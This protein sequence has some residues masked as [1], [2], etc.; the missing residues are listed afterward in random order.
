MSAVVMAGGRILG[1]G[2]RVLGIS[3]SG[4]GGGPPGGVFNFFISTTGS[5][6]NPGTLAE[7]WAITSLIDNSP[8]NS[9]IA[10]KNVGLIAGTYAITFQGGNGAGNF[11]D[12]ILHLPAGT[13]A[14]STYI[15]S[16]N[17][18]GVYTPRAA[19]LLYP[20]QPSVPVADA[21]NIIGQDQGGNGFFTVD[22]IIFDLGGTLP[23]TAGYY[24][25][26][27]YFPSGQS[28][29]PAGFQNCTFQN[30]VSNAVAGD[31]VAFIF[32]ETAANGFVTNCLFQNQARI[33]S[34]TPDTFHTHAL[35]W[36]DCAGWTVSNNSFINCVSAMDGKVN[37][38]GFQIFANYIGPTTIGAIFGFDGDQLTQSATNANVFHHNIF[39]G[40]GQVR[41]ND[42]SSISEQSMTWFNN[43]MLDN[44]SGSVSIIDLRCTGTSIVATSYNNILVS[45]ASSGSSESGT[46][47]VGNPANVALS[48]FNCFAFDTLTDAWGSTTTVDAA[49]TFSTLAGWQ[50]FTGNPDENSIAAASAT[51][52]QFVSAITPGNGPTQYQLSG[53]SPCLNSGRVGGVSSGAAVNMGAWDGTFSIIGA[54]FTD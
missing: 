17:S 3:S 22:G 25:G 52:P 35:E 15:A 51:F 31:N 39:D 6:S 26:A 38:V 28:A 47:S 33:N 54:N 12:P 20:A 24:G 42:V 11:A 32:A 49:T 29:G 43:T 1:S 5:D 7:P 4:G 41:S 10:G 50:G 37:N 23:S 45:T 40:A 48:N 14:A 53:S 44:R 18:S 8:N 46:Y 36:F 13:S 16:C 9:S 21:N 2:S 34:S 30:M 27:S 19:T